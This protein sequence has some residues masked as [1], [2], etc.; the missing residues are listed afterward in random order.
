MAKLSASI[1]QRNYFKDV[2]K[3]KKKTA[4][5]EEF[6]FSRIQSGDPTAVDELVV[7][8]LRYVVSLA[9]KYKC[10]TLTE[11]D[12][13]SEGNIG[14]I[15]AAKRFD[16]SVG[17]KFITYARYSIEQAMFAA[18]GNYDKMIRIPKSASDLVKK[19]KDAKTKLEC[20]GMPITSMAISDITSIPVKDIDKLIRAASITVS[21]D[22]TTTEEDDY[23]L[24]ESLIGDEYTDED[25][26]IEFANQ[27]VSELMRMLSSREIEVIKS[28]YGI[29]QESPDALANRLGLSSTRLGQIR[30]SA[31]SRL[32]SIVSTRKM[33]M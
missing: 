15:K 8:N 27:K 5:E 33:A 16:P 2:K 24:A 6:L 31:I 12:L 21:L 10:K 17:V 29:S 3:V 28:Y 32:S 18:I 25:M 7:S 20:D 19:I 13:I 23:T 26:S 4:Q 14:L 9:R 11:E 22:Q 1:S 30:D